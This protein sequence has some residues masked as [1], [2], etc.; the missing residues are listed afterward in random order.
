MTNI[1]QKVIHELQ[2][3]DFPDLKFLFSDVVLD[4]APKILVDL[5]QID[6]QKFEAFLKKK[7][8]WGI[9]QASRKGWLEAKRQK[10]K[11]G[12]GFDVLSLLTLL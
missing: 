5:L 11:K 4:E 2:K 3:T 7:K 1:H 12:G 8:L 9:A 6:I 10:K